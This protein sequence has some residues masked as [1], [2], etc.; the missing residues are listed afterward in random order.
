MDRDL[1]A[2]PG[3][4]TLTVLPWQPNV[5]RLACD[6]TVEGAPWPFCPRTILRNAL[7]R[8]SA[9]GYQLKVGAELEYFLVR[10]TEIGG[11]EVAD[12]LTTADRAVLFSTW[13]RLLRSN[14]A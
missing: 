2:V 4:T 11:I 3:P 1:I 8:A 7:R 12:A 14:A 5:A 10:R 6:V 9:H 13:S